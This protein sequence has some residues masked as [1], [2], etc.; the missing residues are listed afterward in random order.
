MMG[1]F[2]QTNEG[3]PKGRAHPLGYVI[4]ENGCW[5]WVG[6]IAPNGY[7]QA[8]H[9]GR[10]DYAHRMMYER[11][12]GP[13]GA[14]NDIDHLCRNRGCV[15]PAHMESVPHQVNVV[16]GSGW[17]GRNAAKTHCPQ[18]HALVGDNIR[19]D[20]PYRECAVCHQNANRGVRYLPGQR[21]R[22]VKV[23]E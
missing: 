22:V 12:N 5:E 6:T 9:N 23:E 18:G 19:K 1:V 7:G 21:V 3:S 16:R 13:I 11:A 8:W 10:A 14:G 20:R 15:N 4:Q 2:I 17:A